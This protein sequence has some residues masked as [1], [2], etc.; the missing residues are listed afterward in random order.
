[1]LSTVADS[2]EVSL[3]TGAVELHRLLS[4]GLVQGK[5]AGC[6]ST[7]ERSSRAVCEP[8]GVLSTQS[9]VPWLPRSSSPDCLWKKLTYLDVVIIAA[10]KHH[11][12]N[13]RFV[14]AQVGWREKLGI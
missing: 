3:E 1:M 14:T 7:S 13:L 2:E 6:V 10:T 9:S 12:W 11:G 8:A 4:T 5:K